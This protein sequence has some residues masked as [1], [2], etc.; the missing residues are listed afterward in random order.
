MIH[1]LWHHFM[2][3]NDRGRD[4]DISFFLIY[5]GFWMS[6]IRSDSSDNESSEENSVGTSGFN[7]E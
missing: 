4:L 1:L 7:D 5:E 6:V 3:E 2:R